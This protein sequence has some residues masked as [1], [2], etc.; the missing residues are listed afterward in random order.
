MAHQTFALYPWLP[1]DPFEVRNARQ[2]A[3]AGRMLARFHDEA[4]RL[5]G[6]RSRNLP[7]A[8]RTPEQ[9]IRTIRESWGRRPETEGLI[10]KFEELDLALSGLGFQEALLH[11]D[12]TPGNCV[13]EGAKVCGLFDLDCC[14][15]GRRMLDV[16]NSLMHFAFIET[17]QEG[18]AEHQDD[19][20]LDCARSFLRG[21]ESVHPVP[22]TEKA[23]L[24]LIL[25]RHVRAWMLFN[26]A[27]V[28]EL[29]DWRACEWND[30]VM[31]INLIDGVSERL[32]RG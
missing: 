4:S 9:N 23:Q 3:G 27:E 5:E 8:F 22:E 11:N 30:A 16:A 17:G 7:D 29:G 28:T 21:Y 12:F 19:F 15:W 20:D 14:F 18:V 6:A 32:L 25:R 2:A 1:G 10:A 26:L 31:V 24:A 13:F